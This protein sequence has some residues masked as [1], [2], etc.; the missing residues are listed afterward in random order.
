M[1]N[2]RCL[3]WANCVRL[4]VIA[5]IAPLLASGCSCRSTGGVSSGPAVAR[6]PA[7]YSAIVSAFT[8]SV[9]ALETNANHASDDLI[10]VTHLAPDEPAGWANL[11]LYQLSKNQLKD[12]ARSLAEARKASRPLAI[13]EKLGAQLAEKRGDL[14]GAIQHYQK[15]VDLSPRDLRMRYALAEALERETSA[16]GDAAHQAAIQAILDRQPYNLVAQVKLARIAARRADWATLRKALALL[17]TRS[18]TFDEAAR[19]KLKELKHTAAALN[20]RT[21]A[22]DAQ[23]LLFILENNIGYHQSFI[24]L[25]RPI[26]E[27]P[28]P[29]EQFINLPPM[30]ATPAPADSALTFREASLPGPQVIAPATWLGA[31][32]LTERS[33]RSILTTDKHGVHVGGDAVLPFPGGGGPPSCHGVLVMAVNYDVG[34][35]LVC[36]GGGGVRLY[37]QTEH[38]AFTDVTARTGLAPDVLATPYTGA[39]EADIEADGDLDIVLGSDSGPPLVLRNNGDGTWRAIRPFEGVSGLRDFAWADLDGDGSPDAAMIDAR[40]KLHFFA[41][42]RAGLFRERSLPRT[43]GAVVAL[44][45]ADVNCD[46]RLDILALQS[47]GAILRISDK[48]Q[49]TD[50]D[51]CE[52]ARWTDVA[53]DLAA[54]NSRLVAADLDNN[55][56]MDIIAASP[57]I[58]RVWLCSDRL[59]YSPLEAPIRGAVLDVADIDGNGRL[60]LI[61]LS[62]GRVPARW[63][64]K[65]SKNYSWQEL[66]PQTNPSEI[67]GHATDHKLGRRSGAPSGGVQPV[68]PFGI[69]GE[70]EARAGLL[71]QK[72]VISSPVVH[73]GLGSYSTLDAVR[74]LW[75]NGDVRAEF[76]DTLKTDQSLEMVHRPN[77]SCPFL[78]TWN[79]RE[80]QFV[81]DCIWR[82]PLGLKI[83]AQDTAGVSQTED[84]I[85]IRSDQLAPDR[86][87]MYDLRITAELW[88]THFFDTLSLLAVDHPADTEIFVDERFAVPPP[89]RE[90]HLTRPTRPIKQALDDNGADVTDVVRERDGRYLDSFGRGIYQGVTR[91]HWVEIDIGDN[92]PTS[93]P[94]WLICNGWILPTNSS[95]NVAL[96]QSHLPQPRGLTIETP[97][98]HGH[99][100]VAR[101]GL[102]FPEGKVKTILIDLTGVFKPGAPR[103]LRLHAQREYNV[104]PRSLQD[105]PAYRLHPEDWQIYHTRYVTSDAFHDALLPSRGITVA[106]VPFPRGRELHRNR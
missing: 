30:P 48:D 10:R 33:P 14:A 47:D 96:G 93:G 32:W 31:A 84:W 5:V 99:W 3:S 22:I 89:K 97:D 58:A 36:A 60:E 61:G 41:N 39:W 46:G 87:G 90:V 7:D 24:A 62:H 98:A 82:S 9:I 63:V 66:R 43:I 65:G 55:G 35:D 79:G 42:E 59:T 53:A 17:D 28:D 76:A 25:Q 18:R 8:I 73:I 78:F 103:R 57:T 37:E 94:I 49:G 26:S 67:A 12:A 74:V 72:Q 64:S 104:P 23:S 95:I 29:V 15:A 91:D 21:A 11:A 56:G 1:K 71:Y 38:G 70:I 81:T 86:N 101:P 44:A 27:G 92:A 40:G 68:N 83:N 6:S 102:G 52:I 16:E 54:G 80:M 4:L 77:T 51:I 106:P 50:W 69:G 19:A 45:V 75:P 105:D 13:I 34:N 85:K 2:T 88:E 100:T 20:S